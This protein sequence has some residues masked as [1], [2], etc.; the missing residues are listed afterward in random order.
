[1]AE[2]QEPIELSLEMKMIF[3][4]LMKRIASYEVRMLV[5]N[6]KRYLE[7]SQE[8]D[9]LQRRLERDVQDAQRDQT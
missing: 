5:P 2:P 6:G 9:Q 4:I 3:L 7:V 8:F 1:M